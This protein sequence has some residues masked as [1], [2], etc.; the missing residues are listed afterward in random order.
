[1]QYFLGHF[2]RFDFFYSSV[3]REHGDTDIVVNYFGLESNDF[4]VV[5]E[6]FFIPVLAVENIRVANVKLV[7][8]MIRKG[9][10]IPDNALLYFFTLSVSDDTVTEGKGIE[11]ISM[12]FSRTSLLVIPTICE[13]FIPTNQV[14]RVSKSFD[15]E[16]YLVPIF[17]DLLI[18]YYGF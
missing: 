9:V 17:N 15:I 14:V 11:N 18:D 7:A 4:V 3:F 16:V 8:L 2:N 10:L 1:M 13:P 6:S 12:E 5:F